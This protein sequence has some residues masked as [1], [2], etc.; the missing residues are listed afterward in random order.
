MAQS[1]GANRADHDRRNGPYVAVLKELGQG[2]DCSTI[3]LARE[4]F[5][6][7][8]QRSRILHEGQLL[9]V[10]N[11]HLSTHGS[12]LVAP[13]FDAALASLRGDLPRPRSVRIQSDPGAETR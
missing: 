1:L 3:D 6:T 11:D 12:R 13:A 4:F 9:Y 8:S 2:L 7:T 10:D 5:P